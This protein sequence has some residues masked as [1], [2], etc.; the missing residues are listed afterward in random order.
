MVNLKPMSQST[1]FMSLKY[2]GKRF[3]EHAIPDD[4]LLGIRR[5]TDAIRELARELHFRNNPDS[6]AVPRGFLADFQLALSSV[7]PGSALGQVTCIGSSDSNLFGDV[8]SESILVE[9][10]RAQVYAALDDAENGRPLRHMPV[11]VL[12]CIA[13]FGDGLRPDEAIE[14]M[15]DGCQRPV[16]YTVATREQFSA[17]A[18]ERS[19]ELRQVAV[20]CSVVEGDHR[21]RTAEL[22][23][24]NG[25]RIKVTTLDDA[26]HDA[27]VQGFNGYFGGVRLLVRGTGRYDNRWELIALE[28]IESI[29]VI[30]PISISEQLAR[31]AKFEDGWLDGEGTAPDKTGLKWLAGEFDAHYPAG[32]PIPGIGPTPEGMIE[33]EWRLNDWYLSLEVDLTTKQGWLHSLN[34]KRDRSFEATLNLTL[35]EDWEQLLKY[36]RQPEL[37]KDLV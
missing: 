34:L 4:L 20:L 6:K 12:A 10:A 9:E 28:P 18:I 30:Y 31:I 3:E 21:E 16:T 11:R 36:V 22:E 7:Q 13:R 33:A 25:K 8:S 27:V 32:L 5:L 14:V 23:L 2:K 19:E 1:P 17:A 15:V 29:E 37:T 24:A 35:P 26:Q